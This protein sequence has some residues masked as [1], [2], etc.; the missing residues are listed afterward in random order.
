LRQIVPSASDE[1]T[2]LRGSPKSNE[3]TASPEVE[4][5]SARHSG[6]RRGVDGRY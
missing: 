3:G 1:N 4:R 2:K 5:N 6:T